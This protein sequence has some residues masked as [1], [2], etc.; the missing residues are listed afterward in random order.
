M[1]TKREGGHK[2]EAPKNSTGGVQTIQGVLILNSNQYRI[3]K[4]RS[5]HI[6][7]RGPNGTVDAPY[8]RACDVQI[9]CNSSL[10]KNLLRGA[11]AC[12]TRLGGQIEIPVPHQPSSGIWGVATANNDFGSVVTNF[13]DPAL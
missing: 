1:N 3:Y 7:L 9:K 5:V 6:F 11:R 10:R 4:S 2:T 12:V 8:L 13:S